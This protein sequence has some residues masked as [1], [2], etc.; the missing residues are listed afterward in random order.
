MRKAGPVGFL[1]FAVLLGSTVVRLAEHG[2]VTPSERASCDRQGGR[3]FLGFDG[4]AYCV[5]PGII[6]EWLK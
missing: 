3:L 6:R 2:S 5:T 1:I 4:K